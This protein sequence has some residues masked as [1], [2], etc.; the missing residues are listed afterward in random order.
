MIDMDAANAI[1]S[2][3]DAKIAKAASKETRTTGKVTRIDSDGTVFVM[4]QGSD[5]ETPVKYAAAAVEP[6]EEVTVTISNGSMSIDGNYSRPA[7]D[8]TTARAAQET[9]NNAI[10]SAS[11]AAIA[12]A[13][14]ISSAETAASAAAAAQTDAAAASSAAST[15]Q[16]QAAAA[17]T[18]AGNAS[19]A[20]A[21]AQASADAANNSLK[22]VV[23]GATT[24]EKAV[25][26]MQ[27]ALEAVVDYD[28]TTDTTQEWFWHDSAGAHVLGDTSGYRNDIT[29]SGMDIKQVSSERSVAQFGADGARIGKAYNPQASDNE[30]HMELDYH[31]MK[32]IDKEND[33]YFHVSDLRGEDG[34]ALIVQ[35]HRTASTLLTLFYE[36]VSNS[37]V[38]TKDGVEITFSY[39]SSTNR[40]SFQR[41]DTS[42]H[43]IEIRYSSASDECKNLTFGTRST[44]N[45]PDGPMS[46]SFG[47]NNEVLRRL[48]F[49]FGEG[50]EL[51]FASTPGG[52]FV[53]GRYNQSGDYAAIIGNGTDDSNRSNALAVDWNG[54]VLI[55]G[56]VKNMS[57]TQL[58]ANASHSHSYL[59]LSGGKMTGRLA[60]DGNGTAMPNASTSTDFYAV[61]FRAFVNGGGVWYKGAADFKSWLAPG[62]LYSK[63]T[64]TG[65]DRDGANP[66]SALYG[67]GFTI[68]D[69]DGERVGFIRANRLTDGTMQMQ[70]AVA[71]DN[72]S[73]TEVTNYLTVGINRSGTRSVSFAE[74]AP[75]RTALG[76]DGL[77]KVVSATSSSISIAANSNHSFAP[78]L[79]IPSGYTLVGSLGCK[80]TANNANLSTAACYKYSDT[81]IAAVVCNHSSSAKNVA[82][83]TYGLCVKSICVG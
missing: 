21:T 77:V 83:T 47:V 53:S 16:T 61:G 72:T 80:Y 82:V 7:T 32:L 65:F 40:I 34:F 10:N 43:D 44:S 31:S 54:N 64:A 6:D 69:K 2:A 9:A 81:Q 33:T 79:T 26:V 4:L 66:S 24:V 39:D 11:E 76:L 68:Q 14:A 19:T 50:L 17:V 55:A 45:Y 71:N 3:I 41:T 27:T 49:A 37:I 46:V 70:F 13:S 23:A 36:P 35:H 48:G 12:A 73:G 59:P 52:A 38:V 20:A 5:I 29:S 75:W 15:A 78:T 58:Y 56:D 74:S 42:E 28:P 60:F 22:S 1:E 18:A 62:S 25:S 57:G 63:N 8:D 30:S 51:A 67:E